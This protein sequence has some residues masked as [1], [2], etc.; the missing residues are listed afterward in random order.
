MANLGELGS[1][2]SST[3]GTTLAVT[4]TTG[5]IIPAGTLLVMSYTTDN[6]ASVTAP[7]LTPSSAGGTAW[8]VRLAPVGSGVTTTA[9]SGIWHATWSCRT[10]SSIASGATITT[11]TQTSTVKKVAIINGWSGVSDV[12]RATVVSATSTAG[13]PSAVSTGTALV[14]GDIVVGTIGGENNAAPTGDSDTLNGSWSA[15]ISVFTTGAGAATNVMAGLQ[16]KA[17]TATG[18]QTYNATTAADSIASIMAFVPFAT[19]S[20]AATEATATAS[21]QD[22][23]VSTINPLVNY[24]YTA[25]ASGSQPFDGTAT[26]GSSSTIGNVNFN[27]AG[28]LAHHGFGTLRALISGTAGVARGHFDEGFTGSAVEYRRFYVYIPTGN[29]GVEFANGTVGGAYQWRMTYDQTNQRVLLGNVG[30]SSVFQSATGS[31]PPDQWVRVELKTHGD[32]NLTLRTSRESNRSDFMEELVTTGASFGTST[33]RFSV[34]ITATAATSSVIYLDDIAV[35][36]TDWLGPADV[37]DPVVVRDSAISGTASS[38]TSVTTASGVPSS[39]RV[40]LF[41]SQYSA[42]GT[43]VVTNT[44]TGFGFTWTRLAG[45]TGGT[46]RMYDIWE[47]ERNDNT[48]TSS[49]VVI[50]LAGGSASV[51]EWVYDFYS[52]A[53]VPSGTTDWNGAT[54]SSGTSGAASLSFGSV[55]GTMDPHDRLFVAA[56]VD[57]PDAGAT[58]EAGYT[59]IADVAGTSHL[60]RSYAMLS[61]GTGDTTPTISWTTAAGTFA[62]GYNLIIKGAAAPNNVSLAGQTAPTAAAAAQNPVTTSNNEYGSVKTTEVAAAKAGA[63]DAGVYVISGAP[64]SNADAWSDAEAWSLTHSGGSALTTSASDT[65]G[66]T[67]SRSIDTELARSDSVGETDSRAVDVTL[68]RSDS[69]GLTDSRVVDTALDRADSVGV[70]DSRAVETSLDRSDT[71]GLTDSRAVDDSLDRSDSLGVTDSRAVDTSLDRSDA[72]GVTDARVIDTALN[73]SDA[74]GVTDSHSAELTA[75]FSATDTVN[76]TDTASPVSSF[77]S[78]LTDSVGITDARELSG[79]LDR[80]DQLDLTDSFTALPVIQRTYSDDV[81]VLDSAANTVEL[82]RVDTVGV[83]ELEAEDTGEGDQDAVDLTDSRVVDVSITRSDNVTLADSFVADASRSLAD[84]VSVTDTAQVS[85]DVSRTD[86]VGVTDSAIIDVTLTRSDAV[87]VTDSAASTV[88]QTYVDGVNLTDSVASVKST[89]VSFTDSVGVTDSRTVAI[90]VSATDSLGVTDTQV[91]DVTLSRSDDANI[92]DTYAVTGTGSLSAS[93]NIGVTDSFQLVSD[94]V[95]TFTD[96]V[97]ITDSVGLDRVAFATDS[98]GVT[99]SRALD[100]TLSRADSV[101]LTDSL[102]SEISGGTSY[103]ED[104]N[105]TDSSATTVTADRF[106]SLGLTDSVTTQLGLATSASDTVDVT[107]A[108][109]THRLS[110]LSLE[111][112]TGVTDQ[113]ETLIEHVFS[114][115]ASDGVTITDEAVFDFALGVLA[116][117]LVGVTDVIQVLLASTGDVY[118][119]HPK[120]SVT[121]NRSAVSVRSG[122]AVDLDVHDAS[123]VVI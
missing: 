101:G 22:A 103:G 43:L 84:T 116:T 94:T 4:N 97:T 122:S 49:T 109:T 35:S 30:S 111:S 115:S 87:N 8:N 105:V 44:V 106:S 53:N 41:V 63:L 3:A 121:S 59:E 17:V 72:L 86:T 13:T 65:E 117:N 104:V 74:Q 38:S 34:G 66:V 36:S 62:G 75:V 102:T 57:T 21:A 100:V 9:G 31:L 46:T 61:T 67:D 40:L 91:H 79:S 114:V 96:N 80:A 10:V 45:G 47:G 120:I 99:D 69:L 108:A 112:D 98:V 93:D 68:D 26:S 1:G 25:E 119:R 23:T 28:I 52:F 51:D 78:S 76:L 107:D 19:T 12:L 73:R 37:T 2:S 32:G 64:W 20:P 58:P 56:Y 11:I 71:E 83:T 81:S 110:Q 60:R 14:S 18:A 77:V 5:A 95:V 92:S 54:T 16:N 27:A 29:D 33:G 15:A 88:A 24:V 82:D 123:I 89:D 42:A 85:T 55:T 70:T 48:V 118:I 7:T 90:D 50:T 39:N 6:P 113:F